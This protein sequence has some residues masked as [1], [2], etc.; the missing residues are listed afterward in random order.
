MTIEFNILTVGL[1]VF[2]V[3]LV[4]QNFICFG[5]KRFWSFT[6]V[7]ETSCLPSFEASAGD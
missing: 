5:E 1:D 3:L 2:K 4:R 7:S 6:V